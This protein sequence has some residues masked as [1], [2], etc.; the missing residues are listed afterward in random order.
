MN[1]LNSWSDLRAANKP[2]LILVVL[3]LLAPPTTYTQ[4]QK[5]RRPS[6]AIVS[7]GA[8]KVIT[9]HAGS[10]V[11]INNV[12]HGVTNDK[13]EL[14]LPRVIA[15]SY[16]VRVRTVGFVDGSAS[17]IVSARG[18]KTLRITQQTTTDE[19]TL[20]YQR[21]DALRDKGRNKDA[22]EEWSAHD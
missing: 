19:A 10:V 5:T 12:R 3:V 13:G 18:N 16:P 2:L 8:L 11:F 4:S 17:V 9:G 14:D 1:I 20:H 21:G 22:A 15:G 6:A 7:T